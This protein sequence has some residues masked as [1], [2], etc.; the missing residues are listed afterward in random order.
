MRY[1]RSSEPVQEGNL[2]VL[3]F[4]RRSPAPCPEIANLPLTGRVIWPTPP[5]QKTDIAGTGIG[6]VFHKIDRID[7]RSSFTLYTVTHKTQAQPGYGTDSRALGLVEAPRTQCVY[8]YTDRIE[9]QALSGT[10]SYGSLTDCRGRAPAPA[11]LGALT[12]ARRA[13]AKSWG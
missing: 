4:R 6:I 7:D 5:R 11:A 1:S 2:E 8:R 9:Y 10:S 12:H 3:P 13:V